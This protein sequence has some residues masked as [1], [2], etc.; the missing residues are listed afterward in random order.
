MAGIYCD[1]WASIFPK[2]DFS[3][4]MPAARVGRVENPAIVRGR[5]HLPGRDPA[6]LRSV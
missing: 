4:E 1:A 6:Y 2:I 5:L 3:P